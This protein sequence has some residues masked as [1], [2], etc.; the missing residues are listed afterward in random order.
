MGASGLPSYTWF[1]GPT[2]VLNPNNISIGSAVFAGL[3][4]VTDWPTDHATLSG[5]TGCICVHSTAM[6]PKNSA[7]KELTP[8]LLHE[9]QDRTVYSDDLA[10]LF[11]VFFIISSVFFGSVRQIRLATHQLVGKRE[12]SLSCCKQYTN[13]CELMSCILAFWVWVV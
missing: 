2:R 11:I 9:Y 12:Y 1:P 5:T 6:W 4:S 10:F 8:A 3:T 7:A 13:A